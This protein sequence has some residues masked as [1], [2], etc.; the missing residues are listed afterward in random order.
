LTPAELGCVVEEVVDASA[1]WYLLG[2]QLGLR[3]STLDRIRNQ[4]PDQKMQLTEMLKAWLNADGDHSW[5]VL[6]DALRSQ[7]VEKNYLARVLEE[8]FMLLEI[9]EEGSSTSASNS[10]PETSVIPPPVS[11]PV[12]PKVT[13]QSAVADIQESK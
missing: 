13:P 1:Q 10:Q 8:K 5:K 4:F 6:V 2:L 12:V 11:E 3:H 7:S 9:T